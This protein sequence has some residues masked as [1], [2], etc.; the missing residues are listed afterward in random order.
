MAQAKA[1]NIDQAHG[2]VYFHEREIWFCYLGVNIGSEQDGTRKT[3]STTHGNFQT[4]Q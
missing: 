2:V 3:F 4:I 1:K